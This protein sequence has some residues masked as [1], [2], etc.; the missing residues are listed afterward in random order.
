M[1]VDAPRRHGF[2]EMALKILN[3][4]LH[5]SLVTKGHKTT[6]FPERMTYT[7]L[8]EAAERADGGGFAR[9]GQEMRAR[10]CRALPFADETGKTAPD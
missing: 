1:G 7:A 8:D 9:P 3:R 6:C 2:S 4:I 10:C 5:L